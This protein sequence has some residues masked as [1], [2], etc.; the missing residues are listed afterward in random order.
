M[1]TKS[2]IIG[3]VAVLIGGVLILRGGDEPPDSDNRRE[4]RGSTDDRRLQPRPPTIPSPSHER[5]PSAHHTPPPYG[6]RRPYPDQPYPGGYGLPDP[7]DAQARIRMD[8]YRF[9]PL[10]EQEQNRQHP[11]QSATPYTPPPHPYLPP[12]V[13]PQSAVPAPY[14]PLLAPAQESYSFRPL[15]K[16]PGARGRWQGPYGQPGQHFDRYST[17]LWSPSPPPQWGSTPPSQQMYPNL[18][19]VPGLPKGHPL[20]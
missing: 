15:K 18:H 5:W 4:D 1:I 9:R 8:G 6:E 12:K 17:D 16:S 13:Q 19:R 7:Y 11:G 10:A 2:R 3:L 20:A 14:P